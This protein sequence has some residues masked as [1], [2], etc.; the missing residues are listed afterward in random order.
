MIKKPSSSNKSI[1]NLTQILLE[2]LMT[3]CRLEI[4]IKILI[5]RSTYKSTKNQKYYFLELRKN[6]STKLNI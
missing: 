6:L 2:V 4:L 3:F 1:N 5:H